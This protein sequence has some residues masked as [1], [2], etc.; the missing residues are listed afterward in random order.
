MRWYILLLCCFLFISFQSQATAQTNSNQPIEITADGTLE[1]NRSQLKFIARKNVRTVQ[2]KTTLYSDLLTAHYRE[3]QGGGID[4]RTIT[5]IGQ[6]RII[7]EQGRAYGEK[8][9]Y[10]TQNTRAVM[11]GNN[12]KLVSDGQ[13]VTARDKFVYSITQGRLEAHGNAVAIQEGDRLQADKMIAIFTQSKDGKRTLKTLEAIG[14]VIITTPDEV[15]TGESALYTASTETAEL[16]D[17][18]YITRGP[19]TLQGTRAQINLKT[20]ISKIFGGK[21][22]QGTK[23]GRVR[24]IFYPSS[25]K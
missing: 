1:W 14:N 4:I 5:A 2:D 6:V 25:K 16:K 20:N 21:N 8:A 10:D 19:N 12:L 24:G 9:V 13:T 17:N 7:S 3:G 11:T 18:V 22:T 15:L 23:N